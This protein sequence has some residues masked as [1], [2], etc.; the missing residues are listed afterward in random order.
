MD[1]NAGM[2]V[3]VKDGSSTEVSSVTLMPVVVAVAA[4]QATGHH[5]NMDNKEDE[6][7]S[8]D[9]SNTE[10]DGLIPTMVIVL[11]LFLF[12]VVVVVVVM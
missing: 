1:E 6:H 5:T 12:L 4:S 9:S 10:L 8:I 11:R 3:V 2:D 7:V